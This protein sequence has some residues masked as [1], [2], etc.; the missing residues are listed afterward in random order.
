MLVCS[1]LLTL[2]LANMKLV[3]RLT[4]LHL[5]L[6]YAGFSMLIYHQTTICYTQINSCK[7]IEIRKLINYFHCLIIIYLGFY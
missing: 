2:N 3:F 1:V 5:K 6:L 4:T 7:I